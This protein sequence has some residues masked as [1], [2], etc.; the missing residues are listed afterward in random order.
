MSGT[1]CSSK[2]G[3]A[4]NEDAGEKHQRLEEHARRISGELA[5]VDFDAKRATL[6]AFGVKIV[7]G[8]GRVSIELFV[9]PS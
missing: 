3:D 8:E 5:S 9:D 2:T 6:L 4:F 7:V 1:C